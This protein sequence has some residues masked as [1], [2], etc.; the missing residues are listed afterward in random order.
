MKFSEVTQFIARALLLAVASGATLAAEQFP[1]RPIRIVV[2]FPPGG[3]VDTLARVITA[4]LSESLGR[5]V[6]IDNRPGGGGLIG[7][8]IAAQ[9]RADG[10]TLL[11]QGIPFV[12]AP[13]L[14]PSTGYD[15]EKDF[16][17]V[18]LVA[19]TPIVLVAH[20][21][22]PANSLK[23]FVA[24]AKAQRGKLNMASGG[25]GAT[26]HLAAELF[27]LTTGAPFTHIP[28]KGMGPAVADVI[29]GQV[30]SI[31]ATLP[32]ALPHIRAGKLKALVLT[33]P[34][35]SQSSPELPT[36]AEAGFAGLEVINWYG[37][38]APKGVPLTVSNLISAAVGDVLDRKDVKDR[39]AAAGL[40][41]SFMGA[42]E[43]EKFI[44]AE[45]QRW[46]RVVKASGMR[47]E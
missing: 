37:L 42:R 16:A 43:F 11:F 28:Y 29:S 14:S 38:L 18:V 12:V 40:D 2:P 46:S 27:R 1:V 20:P 19:S 44:R 31:F 34:K 8:Q 5:Q 33:S 22:V 13:Q 24:H 4:P 26:A 45:V 36:S 10:Y 17:P 9:A 35:R 6:V 7:N 39:L 30:D 47:V 23:E 21:G 41:A 15:P 25:N 32:S 3:G